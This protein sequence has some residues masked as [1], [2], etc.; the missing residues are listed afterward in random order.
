MTDPD[1][2]LMALRE[3]Y[4][5]GVTIALARRR[6]VLSGLP[7]PATPIG[8][9]ESVSPLP[10][11]YVERPELQN[12]LRDLILG[13]TRTFSVTSV[14][15]IGGIGKTELARAVC[16]DPKIRDAFCDGIVWIEVGRESRHTLLEC[17]KKV[18]VALNGD[19]A[20]YT[21]SNCETCYCTL[22]ATKAV[23]IVLDDVWG[24][25]DVEPFIMGAPRCGVL[26]TTRDA[27]L[28]AELG[29]KNF[30]VER[31]TE[32]QS[33]E[34]LAL[35]SRRKSDQLPAV[36]EG[37]IH[38]CGLLP[39]G[40]R[41]IGSALREKLDAKWSDTLEKLRR[42]HVFAPHAPTKV[43]VDALAERDEMLRCRYLQLAV[44]LEHMVAPVAILETLW[45]VDT[46]KVWQTVYE[47]EKRSLVWRE[48]GGIRLHD[49]ALDYVRGEHPD[50]EALRS[51]HQML[52][53]GHRLSLDPWFIQEFQASS[54]AT[55][56]RP[57]LNPLLQA[58]TPPAESLIRTLGG[59]T[60]SI[61]SLTV[62]ADGRRAVSASD[63]CTLKVWDVKSGRQLRTLKGHRDGVIGAAVSVDDRRVVSA[64]DDRTLKV[65]DV[66]S[67]LELRT[68]KGH[69][70]GVVGVAVSAN[71]RRAVSASGQTV[72]VWDV[73]SGLELRTLEGH[74]DSVASVAMS[75]DGKVA[76]SASFDRTLKVWDVDN[77]RELRTLTGHQA[78]VFRV[79]LSADGKVA[80]SAAHQTLKVW[81][82]DSGQELRTLEGHT[83]PVTSVAVGADGRRAA[84]ASVDKTVRT[85][86]VKSGNCMATFI[87]DAPVLCCAMSENVIAAGDEAGCLHFVPLERSIAQDISSPVLRSA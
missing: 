56:P 16:H 68:M 20:F 3:V 74:A 41:L 55:T 62:S 24:K 6:E 63:D 54:R 46:A 1:A 8:P 61:W 23:L 73:E 19:P 49:L 84:S 36:A 48:G 44:L 43:S 17:M 26:F 66:E 21:V 59:H 79:A 58:L 5:R 33:R 76:V 70:D 18:A 10:L 32:A 87:F 69:V 11:N 42:A 39:L 86:D 40:L 31:L 37:I 83:R 35:C 27:S 75:A 60:K 30:N 80:L 50:Q 71:G 2:L 25:A 65:W 12:R 4:E 38:E 14:Q 45:N 81:D 15:G 52:R 13:R 47:L 29:A 51:V 64:S 34:V 72:K 53:S 77:G 78:P 22:L 57:W 9:C 67:G 7:W 85:W 28:A 82:V